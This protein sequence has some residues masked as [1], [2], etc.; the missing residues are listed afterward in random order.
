MEAPSAHSFAL[1]DVA[2]A[3]EASVRVEALSAG[4]D[5]GFGLFRG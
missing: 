2:N 1:V 3:D 4:G 5:V